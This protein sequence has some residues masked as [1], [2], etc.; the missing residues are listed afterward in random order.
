MQKLLTILTRDTILQEIY[1]REEELLEQVDKL[2]KEANTTLDGQYK[3]LSNLKTQFHSKVSWFSFTNLY[4]DTRRNF[5][6]DESIT[7]INTSIWVNIWNFQEM[8]C[9][10]RLEQ[11]IDHEDLKTPAP[12]ITY[13]ENVQQALNFLKTNEA[14]YKRRWVGFRT[15]NEPNFKNTVK[16]LGFVGISDPRAVRPWR[17]VRLQIYWIF[18]DKVISRGIYLSN[19]EWALK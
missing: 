16:V 14:N 7:T 6:F 15:A 19:I 2:V 11:E 18:I 3:Q 13:Q 17:L 12:L 4:F 5:K 1:A 9:S 10:E 8:V